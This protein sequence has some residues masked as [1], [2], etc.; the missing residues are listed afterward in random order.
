M[1]VS[2]CHRRY[3]NLRQGDYEA[4]V[5]LLNKGQEMMEAICP[6]PPLVLEMPSWEVVD[7]VSRADE[8]ALSEELAIQ[9]VQWSPQR[10]DFI[11]TAQSEDFASWST[12]RMFSD[13]FVQ[14]YR[15][16]SSMFRVSMPQ[17]L[18]P[19]LGGREYVYGCTGLLSAL[20]L[21]VEFPRPIRL[22]CVDHPDFSALW[23]QTDNGEITSDKTQLLHW[24]LRPLFD[25]PILPAS[26]VESWIEFTAESRRCVA[27]LNRVR[28]IHSELADIE[29]RVAMEGVERMNDGPD[30]WIYVN[31]SGDPVANSALEVYDKVYA[32]MS[33][34]QQRR[35]DLG[36]SILCLER[37]QR[38]VRDS[39][40]NGYA[41]G[42]E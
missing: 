41:V 20:I 1:G 11:G 32:E 8:A 15:A 38:S 40:D 4:F 25:V 18:M 24:Y 16:P 31:T 22:S 19:L 21:P 13:F 35:S 34:I 5:G 28:D 23:R 27:E 33:D 39:R 6:G 2:I 17:V 10:V 12:S 29:E 7:Q 36:F 26:T 42:F 3:C 14:T 30:H 37:I 9:G